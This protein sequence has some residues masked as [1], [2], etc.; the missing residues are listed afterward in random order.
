MIFGLAPLPARRNLSR[1]AAKRKVNQLK[2]LGFF[3]LLVLLRPGEGACAGDTSKV[4]PP[5]TVRV[6]VDA[7][8][9]P[10]ALRDAAGQLQ[11]LVRDRWA[12]WQARTGIAV[13]LHAM[14][15][16]LAQQALREGRAD[17]IDALSRTPLREPFYDFSEPYA[18]L[19]V[20]L[21]FRDRIAGIVDAASTR[22]VPVGVKEGDRCL[23]RLKAAGADML[24]RYPSDE[25]VVAAAV[26]DEIAVFCMHGPPAEYLL[27]R[28]GVRAAFRQSRPLYTSQF[29]WAVREGEAEL[30]RLVAQGFARFTP[31]DHARLREKWFGRSARPE[32][33]PRW[34]HAGAALAILAAGLLAAL[35]WRQ[36]CQQARQKT[37]AL[38]AE[39]AR[40]KTLFRMLP[41]PAW[42]RDPEGGVLAC[43]QAFERLFGRPQAD[44]I[45]QRDAQLFGPVARDTLRAH[46]RCALAGEEPVV[47]Q[48]WLPVPA[49]GRPRLFLLTKQRVHEAGGVLLGV[50]NVARD[51]TGQTLAEGALSDGGLDPVRRPGAWGG[52]GAGLGPARQGISPDCRG[53]PS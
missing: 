4:V 21:F 44:L 37:A 13:E 29:H 17:V 28:A 46:D 45:G 30:F 42:L 36:G 43:N 39:C 50:L 25:A 12:L 48:V 32:A 52:R 23:D 41:D 34:F 26:R 5:R 19:D 31:Q 18:E 16:A 8:L 35:A 7:G 20:R 38:E 2:W 15:E 27:A 49:L 11:G 14:E 53:T 40:F 24:V 47:F 33:L 51:V 6:V 3:L 22:G 10:Y 9:P 1:E